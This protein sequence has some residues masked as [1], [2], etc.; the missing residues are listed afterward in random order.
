MK[1][2]VIVELKSGKSW[3][4]R[5]PAPQ[6]ASSWFDT[7]SARLRDGGCLIFRTPTPRGPF[8]TALNPERIA[9]IRLADA[10]EVDSAEI[11]SFE[12]E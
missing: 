8:I 4:Y 9:S 12:A 5:F 1:S 2:C 10:Q 6:S 3:A 7:Y 11:I